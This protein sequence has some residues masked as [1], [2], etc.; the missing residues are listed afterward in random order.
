MGDGLKRAFAA[1]KATRKIREIRIATPGLVL[2]KPEHVTWLAWI[3]TLKTGDKVLVCRYPDCTAIF[4]TT[5]RVDAK[6]KVR[7]NDGSRE[8]WSG[9]MVKSLPG[10][11]DRFLAPV[12]A[13]RIVVTHMPG[14]LSG[15]AAR[16]EPD[17]GE[18]IF[19]FDALPLVPHRPDTFWDGGPL[20]IP[21]PAYVPTKVDDMTAGEFRLLE[22]I[23]EKRK[24][25]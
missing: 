20:K 16:Y 2:P 7:L 3:G 12:P 24:T 4:E 1:A 6:G 25:P 19:V 23:L 21:G 13:P 8:E 15:Y 10:G 11:G 14:N 18:L 9:Y 22:A 5:V 17:N